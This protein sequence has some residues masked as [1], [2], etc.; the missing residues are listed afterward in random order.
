MRLARKLILGEIAFFLLLMGGLVLTAYFLVL[1]EVRSIEKQVHLENIS[2]INHAFE[3]ELKRIKIFTLDWAEWDDTYD[4]VINRNPEF[5]KSSLIPESLEDL[6]IDAML[7][8]N[9]AHQFVWKMSTD[10]IGNLE[11]L[12]LFNS[13]EW[14]KT[15]PLLQHFSDTGSAIFLTKK[16]AVFI[17]RH[18]ILTSQSE[19][20]S[21]GYL[22]FARL[23]DQQFIQDTSDTLEL[24]FTAD[25]V[26]NQSL[27]PS[28]SFVNEHES[29]SISY[30]QFANS[31]DKV[32]RLDITQG[33]PFY[34][35]AINAAQ[36]SL[37]AILIIGLLAC[38]M[39]YYFLKRLLVNPIVLLQQQ[40]KLFSPQKDKTPFSVLHRDDEIGDLSISFSN[41]A[42]ELASHV[43][44]LEQERDEFE[45][46]S[47]TDPLTGLK[48]R[49]FLNDFMQSEQTWRFPGEWTVFTLDLDHFKHVNDA[50]GHDEGDRVLQ[51][52]SLLIKQTCRDQ[53]IVVR[54]GG[55]EF[56]I[57]CR[58]TGSRTASQIAERIRYTT[59]Q[60]SFGSE[61]PFSV[62]CSLGFFTLDITSPE[63][64][65]KYWE[66]MI[67]VSDL[68][69]YAAKNNHRN[70]WV[71][72]NC[73]LE[74]ED[75]YYP[76]N[77]REILKM[78]K[79]KKLQQFYPQQG[80]QELVWA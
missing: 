70:T 44:K 2:R 29:H 42:R 54:S 16:G 19:G 17:A 26:T 63:Q 60:T 45:N 7:I 58:Q 47:Y 75:G 14:N 71:G 78:L 43:D 51:Q 34:Q 39:T 36:L 25:I 15:S 53:D 55:E 38:L 61:K 50:Y 28:V 18:P 56:T 66:S 23:L 65:L 57:I 27:K 74:C 6:E 68:A 62:T 11:D 48:N 10:N 22:F 24:D 67:K 77:T 59:E 46:A 41:M 73:L 32:L 76:S 21:R 69:L 5:E 80:H 64:G 35:Q 52:F 20:P 33:R 37:I 49:R 1:P 72:L 4:Y 40:A 79:E 13:S 3:N 12:D 9:N 8:T 31:K 30:Y